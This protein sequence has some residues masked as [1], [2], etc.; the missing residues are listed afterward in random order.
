[1]YLYR[2]H[3]ILRK[4]IV[5]SISTRVQEADVFY[6]MSVKENR[7]WKSPMAEDFN[8]CL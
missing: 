6:L 5:A 1:M 4:Q 7:G 8:G 2:V 3:V